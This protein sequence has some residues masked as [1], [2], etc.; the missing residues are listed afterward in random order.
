MTAAISIS[1]FSII[2]DVLNNGLDFQVKEN[3]RISDIVGISPLDMEPLV[4]PND[5]IQAPTSIAAEDKNKAD[6]QAEVLST[7]TSSLNVQ[8]YIDK[9]M[10]NSGLLKPD[11]EHLFQSFH[12]MADHE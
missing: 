11:Q 5:S 12:S 9:V 3:P 2:Q 8:K 1:Y 7:S 10:M 4:Y 6:P